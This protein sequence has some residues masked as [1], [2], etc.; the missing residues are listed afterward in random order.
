M[1]NVNK[2]AAR[3][4]VFVKINCI[5][6]IDPILSQLEKAFS[7]PSDFNQNFNDVCIFL[8]SE[9]QLIGQS[10]QGLRSE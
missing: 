6:D 7:H 5:K 3:S 4:A 8:I 2:V 10:C 1:D 9:K